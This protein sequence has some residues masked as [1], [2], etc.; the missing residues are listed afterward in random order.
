MD[1]EQAAQVIEQTP[2]PVEAPASEPTTQ[3]EADTA[4]APQSLEQFEKQQ[5]RTR[6]RARSQ[7]ASPADVPRIRELTAKNAALA[8]EVEALK[9]PA[10]AS[11]P[12]AQ[13]PASTQVRPAVAAVPPP[14]VAAA[15]DPEPTEALDP[16]TGKP[17]ED[18]AKFTRDS[19]RWAAREEMRTAR[20]AWE[21]QTATETAAAENARLAE[22]WATNVNAAKTQHADFE[23]IAYGPAPWPAGSLIDNWIK[24][25]PVGPLVLY[26]LKKNPAEAHA[27]LAMGLFEQTEA[28]SLLSQRLRPKSVAAVST[29]AAPVVAA[30]P[31]PRPPTPVRTG[32]MRVD[33]AAPDPDSLSLDGF[34]EAT[35]Y[36]GRRRG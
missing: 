20:A 19:A 10:V 23:A 36:A 12:P 5:P 30:Q 18:F 28:L 4:L 24:E 29:G 17:Y 1:V 8:A 2:A 13:S 27:M 21:T 32:P 31:V 14:V 15:K 26:S 16:S 9:K 33:P 25:H 7:E 34:A 3:A 22:S 35:G 6:H 11:P